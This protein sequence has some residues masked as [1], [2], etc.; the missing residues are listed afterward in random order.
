MVDCSHVPPVCVLVVHECILTRQRY[1]CTSVV[2]I[3]PCTA[4]RRGFA[5]HTYLL[6]G[7]EHSV[8]EHFSKEAPREI[9]SDRLLM[10]VLL[11]HSIDLQGGLH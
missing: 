9:A 3:V 2:L 6:G 5:V 11:V 1:C 4:V 10:V 8:T 7:L